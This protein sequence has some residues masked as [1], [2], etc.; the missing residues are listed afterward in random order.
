MRKEKIWYSNQ[1]VNRVNRSS[2]RYSLLFKKWVSKESGCSNFKVF[3]TNEEVSRSISKRSVLV[4]KRS[5]SDS[6]RLCKIER[7]CLRLLSVKCKDF[8]LEIFSISLKSIDSCLRWFR[9]KTNKTRRKTGSVKREDFRI[10][11]EMLGREADAKTSPLTSFCNFS[12]KS[13]FGKSS[14]WKRSGVG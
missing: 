13:S 12:Q 11:C 2:R 14:H 1:N 6:S 7:F 4:T 10:R 3:T 9:W 5:Y 8:S